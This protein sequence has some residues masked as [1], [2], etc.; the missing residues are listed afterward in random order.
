M[1]K[2][3]KLIFTVIAILLVNSVFSQ[4]L[5]VVDKVENSFHVYADEYGDGIT[6]FG[7]ESP[8]TKSKK[9]ICI[10][11]NTS[12]VEDNPHNCLLGAYYTTDDLVIEYISTEGSFVK[13]SIIEADAGQFIFYVE[14]KN[15]R[16]D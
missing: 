15:V 5:A 16:F 7:Y 13:L 8:S 3:L 2:P 14:T 1:K 6:I 12:D 10:S 4:N 9:M 11:P